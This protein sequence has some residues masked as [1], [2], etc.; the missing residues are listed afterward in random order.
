MKI[1][2]GFEHYKID[3]TDLCMKYLI[4]NNIICIPSSDH[5]RT[6]YFGDPLIDV[7]KKIYITIGEITNE[8]DINCIIKIN[9]INNSVNVISVIEIMNKLNYIHNKYP[10]KHGSWQ[11]EI[12]EQKMVVA[13][14]T[15]K[16][17]VLEIGS[18][19]GR[20]SIVIS[21]ILN[22]SKNLL[23]LEC[24]PISFNKLK[25]NKEINKL[26]FNIENSALSK[27]KLI[28]REWNTIPSDELLEG[29]NWVNTITYD[30]LKNKYN[31]EFDTLVLDCE[32]AF[33]YILNDM[34][35]ILN[36]INLIIMENDYDQMEQKL[37]IDKVLRNNNFY[38]DYVD[39][40]DYYLPCS[41]H[42]FEVWIKSK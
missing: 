18:N 1:L 11:E 12:D 13:Y 40:I 4:D 30:E 16:E 3:V 42:F 25:E 39:G 2:Y 26:D 24:D 6:L 21:S 31:I 29:W 41:K 17:K 38:R 28:Q 5:S 33:Y 34:P 7:C 14:F 23:T 9:L 19:I 10:I 36:N 22:D 35:N 27:R 37:Y 8:Y 20:N 32:G 15:G